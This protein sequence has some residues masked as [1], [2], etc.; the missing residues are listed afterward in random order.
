[1][2]SLPR[3]VADSAAV[4]KASGLGT[5]P[6]K[7]QEEMRDLKSLD[8]LLPTKDKKT[9][10]LRVVATAPQALKVLLQRMKIP[11][12]NRP[13]IIENIMQKT[14]ISH[15]NYPYLLVSNF[16]TAEDGLDD[17]NKSFICPNDG[18]SAF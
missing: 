4:V 7:L 8:V 13:R 2:F 6:R 9:I 14:S 1:M 11:L 12:P 17:R 10:S 5:A 18:K 15:R 3:I 16:I